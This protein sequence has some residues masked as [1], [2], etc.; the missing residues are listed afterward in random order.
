MV[1][2][3]A[4]Y[5][6]IIIA[7]VIALLCSAIIVS[8]YF[9]KIE[10]QKK[11]R[12]SQLH[13]NLNSGI[14]I[15]LASTDAS[16]TSQKTVSLLSGDA[17]SVSLQ[18][19]DWGIY[20]TGVVKAFIQ[21][22][23]LYKSFSFASKIDSANWAAL[24]LIDQDRPF[25]LSGKTTIRGDAY[26]PKAGVQAAYIDGK[27]YEGDKRFIIGKKHDSKRLLPLL[28][29][30]KLKTFEEYFTNTVGGDTVLMA[31]D[32]LQNSF[33]RPTHVVNF[34]KTP[35]IISNLRINGNIVLFSDTTI[36]VDSTVFLKMCRF[37]QRAIII[38]SGFHGTCQLFA[39]DSI[40]VEARCAFGYPSSLGV[41]RFHSSATNSPIR[42]N[43]GQNTNFWGAIFTYDKTGSQMAPFITLQKNTKITGQVYSQGMLELQD[44][45]EIDG[46]AFTSRFIYRN[47]TNLF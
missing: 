10:Y 39:T 36:T 47:T 37:T 4:L 46:S 24:Y 22:D 16:F 14:N 45:T 38:K 11:F 41:L 8:A 17:D 34:K 27:A 44:K 42:I 2:A 18:K 32:S 5:I 26:I 29:E 28:D 6:V 35:K 20:E 13:S 19:I 21:K 7:L 33:L 40:R 30:S 43:V 1:K 25:S 15:L 9:Y 12:Y 23:T 3:S 31:K